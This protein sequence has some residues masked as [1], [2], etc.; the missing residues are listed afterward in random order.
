MLVQAS[1]QAVRD[2]SD[3][4][5]TNASIFSNCA[6]LYGQNYNE[7]GANPSKKTI[8]TVKEGKVRE[9]TG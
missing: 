6:C 7:V 1:V 3:S 2:S 9:S 5:A 4:F 8:N